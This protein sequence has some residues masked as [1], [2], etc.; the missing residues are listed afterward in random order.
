M[1]T[2]V[3]VSQRVPNAVYI[4]RGSK[5]GNPFP[6]T[7][8]QTREQVIEKYRRHLWEQ[9]KA[10]TITRADLI[11]LDSKPLACF[12]APLPCHGDVIAA[13]VQWAKGETV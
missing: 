1:N 3:R 11:A 7:A 4:G 9:I 13:A 6:I 12:C 8:T 10:G 2:V 5:W